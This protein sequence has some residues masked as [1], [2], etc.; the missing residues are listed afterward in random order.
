MADGMNELFNISAIVNAQMRNSVRVSL[1][2]LHP[3]TITNG[4]VGSNVHKLR[5]LNEE[6][7]F[8]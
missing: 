5:V 2:R 3:D 1:N 6:R 4:D 8:A 7:A